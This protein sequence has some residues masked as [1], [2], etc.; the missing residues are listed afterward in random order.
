MAYP[1]CTINDGS[2]GTFLAANAIS[3]YQRCKFV[4]PASGDGKPS[5]DVCGVTERGNVIAMQPIA[6]GE[7]GT[8]RFL[9]AP[10]EQFGLAIGTIAVADAVYTDVTGKFSNASHDS[11]VIVGKCTS[12]G[13]DGGPFTWTP[14]ISAA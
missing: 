7:Y 11:N 2:Y 5:I 9:N 6:Q 14:Q 8:V 10:G 4:T 13:Y 1:N 12:A 3:L